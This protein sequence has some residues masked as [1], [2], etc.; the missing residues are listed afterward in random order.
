MLWLHGFALFAVLAIFGL[1]FISAFSVTVIMGP[2]LFPNNRESLRAWWPGSPSGWRDRCNPAGSHRR[3]IGVPVEIKCIGAL[4]VSGFLL[5][6]VPRYP[7][8]ERLK[9]RYPFRALNKSDIH[10]GIWK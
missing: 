5:A 4:P 10:P 1:I 7:A 8:A 2:V 9:K 6:I 3:T